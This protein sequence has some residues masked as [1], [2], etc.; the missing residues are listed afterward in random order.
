M[1]EVL[2]RET[3]YLLFRKKIRK[4]Y[5]SFIP[6]NKGEIRFAE[7][8]TFCVVVHRKGTLLGCCLI[9][10]AN[11]RTRPL[12]PPK[13]P[14]G[15]NTLNNVQDAIVKLEFSWVQSRSFLSVLLQSLGIVPIH[16]TRPAQ[17]LS[18]L[19]HRENLRN[20]PRARQKKCILRLSLRQCALTARSIPIYLRSMS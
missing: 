13:E 18:P 5:L 20:Y 16:R 19:P 2:N 12:G 10:L 8:S 4:K 1:F 17:N 14:L 3:G 7:Q 9:W 11:M 6:K 15:L